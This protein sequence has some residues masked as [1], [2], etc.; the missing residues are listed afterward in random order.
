MIGGFDLGLERAGFEI[1]WQVE[2]DPYCT[3][4]LA[5]HWPNV[6]RYGD[7]REVT[8]LEPVD[9]ICGGFPCQDISNAGFRAGIG[10]ARSGLWSEMARLIGEVRPRY[11]LVE[12]VA[13][14]LDR[15]M[16]R[17]LGDLAE[18]G[19][20]AEWGVFRASNFGAPH[21]RERIYICAY[22]H[23]NRLEADTNETKLRHAV[24]GTQP[25][26]HLGAMG[27]PNVWTE[28]RPIGARPMGVGNGISSDVDRLKGLGNAVVPQIVEWIGRQIVAFDG[29]SS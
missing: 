9:L 28:A 7:I 11:V 16:G 23:G 10:G 5:K 17:V 27:R 6:K 18:I 8:E 13:A 4:V 1:R 14:L 26:G 24:L 25:N 3:R 12:N 19:Y 20:D 15:G 2:I 29:A 22:P 21:A